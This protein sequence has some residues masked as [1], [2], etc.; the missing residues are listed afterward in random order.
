MNCYKYMFKE[1]FDQ[2]L[3]SRLYKYEKKMIKQL[4]KILSNADYPN[5]DYK[6]EYNIL[7]KIKEPNI[8]K[9]NE[10]YE[11]T[12]YFYTVMDY[13]DRG[14]LYFNINNKRLS[15]KDYK[16]LIKK[17]IEP[18]FIIHKL[19]IVHMD[20]KL[21]N[22]VLGNNY[23]NFIL[24]DFNLSKIHNSNYYEPET[25]KGVIGTKP[26]I[27]PEI[28]EGYYCKSSDMYSLGCMLYLIYTRNTYS[29]NSNNF[30]LLSNEPYELQTIIKELLSDNYKLRPSI[31][32]LK[33]LLK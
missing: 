5:Y 11:D 6:N 33:Y 17:I 4:P 8:I 9:I 21:E 14:D 1:L 18:I 25:I 20:L 7:K 30:E 19:N 22:Y 12:D 24:I 16:K 10:T 31:Y 32:D 27:A 15:V 28:Y 13:Y 23:D 26:F 2:T 29:P 3:F